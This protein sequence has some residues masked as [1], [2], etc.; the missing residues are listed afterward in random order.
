[1]E[2]YYQ[3]CNKELYSKVNQ[4]ICLHIHHIISR[5]ESPCLTFDNKNLIKKESKW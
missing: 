3:L 4:N 1:M 5:V 2:S